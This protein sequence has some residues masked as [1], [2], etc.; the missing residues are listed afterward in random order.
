VQQRA[1]QTGVFEALLEVAA[2]HAPEDEPRENRRI[3]LTEAEG[4]AELGEEEAAHAE[5]V[6]AERAERS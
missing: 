1:E 4:Q 3:D 5:A 2:R 6:E